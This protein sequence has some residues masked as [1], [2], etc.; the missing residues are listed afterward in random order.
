MFYTGM[1]SFNVLAGISVGFQL[2][3]I[4]K[5]QFALVEFEQNSSACLCLGAGAEK[6]GEAQ[7]KWAGIMDYSR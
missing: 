5:P 3:S 7:R 2:I 6:L 1:Q 4:F